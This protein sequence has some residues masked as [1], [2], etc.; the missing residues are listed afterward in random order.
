MLDD[1]IM[2]P[3]GWDLV[4]NSGPKDAPKERLTPERAR[5]EARMA[6]ETL[7]SY[8]RDILGYETQEA[9]AR[10]EGDPG[11]TNAAPTEQAETEQLRRLILGE[12]PSTLP[13]YT[14]DKLDDLGNTERGETKAQAKGKTL[15]LQR[16]TTENPRKGCF[17]IARNKSKY[18]FYPM[19]KGRNSN[20]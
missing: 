16:K 19:D 18:S 9:Q 6:G 2:D 14:I 11:G 8:R 10:P 4:D 5:D 20:M 1:G 12:L 7:A 13:R 17:I 15:D 3:D